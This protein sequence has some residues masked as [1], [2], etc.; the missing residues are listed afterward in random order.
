MIY[1][2]QFT[3]KDNEQYTV[4]ITSHQLPI[5]EC[6]ITFL[7]DPVAI[8]FESENVFSPL[9]L[10]GAT[11]R[12]FT[13]E[14]MKDIYS[15]QAKEVEVIIKKGEAIVWQ[16]YVSPCSYDNEFRK[17]KKEIEIECYDCLSALNHIKYS[18]DKHEIR[19]FIDIIN[20]ALSKCMISKGN[21]HAPNL[22]NELYIADQN[23]FDEEGEA[24]TYKEVIQHLLTYA[25]YS[26]MLVGSD[27]FIIDVNDQSATLNLDDYTSEMGATI[28]MQDVY[29]KIK[30]VSSLYSFSTLLPELNDP[31]L[32][33][34][35][36]Q[37]QDTWKFQVGGVV[38]FTRTS[39]AKLLTNKEFTIKRLNTAGQFVEV[40][41]TD[42]NDWKNYFGG[43]Y[44]KSFTY[45]DAI[46]GQ[47]TRPVE[48][49]WDY[50]IAL[51]NRVNGEY[52][53]KKAGFGNDYGSDKN[54][55]NHTFISVER[56]FGA[57]FGDGF[58]CLSL[59]ARFQDTTTKPFLCDSDK[60]SSVK[61]G[62]IEVDGYLKMPTVP[63]YIKVGDYYFVTKKGETGKWQTT[64]DFSNVYLGNKG[65]G[66]SNNWLVTKNTNVNAN[67]VP[68]LTG[69]VIQCPQ[70]INA[71]KIT[72]EIGMPDPGNV[73]AGALNTPNVLAEYIF[74]RDIKF[75]F[76]RPIDYSQET[77]F[78]EEEF[79]ETDTI[80]ESVINDNNVSEFDDIKLKVATDNKK[81]LSFASVLRKDGNNFTFSSTINKGEGSYPAEQYLLNSYYNH[82]STPKEVISIN[83]N[84]D[85]QPT[86]A[87]A[88][89]E[90]KFIPVAMAKHLGD[91]V[92]ELKLIQL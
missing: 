33:R 20:D 15:A 85:A 31:K 92:T 38:L 41:N 16:G 56:E 12:V 10:S 19:S 44:M 13:T 39:I 77:L 5:E 7:P 4:A 81:G 25:G 21:V 50:Y 68:S 32:V 54:T 79:A 3:S 87:F 17:A 62:D 71:D 55:F 35:G 64:R 89:D 37:F 14:E 73:K 8:T 22:L 63:V 2:G 84:G 29:N 24:M 59:D 45:L 26:M 90:K 53:Q 51:N 46:D 34:T 40:N 70:V 83:I 1:K 88:I 86:D 6:G 52:Y 80:W 48:D 82:Y 47:T 67:N 57:A 23:W 65:D 43:T 78:T 36:D 30:I 11:L 69:F 72:L 74:V 27:I 28:S 9:R 66:I 91:N 42:I 61:V 60:E 18:V 49:K 58:F 75:D 76:A